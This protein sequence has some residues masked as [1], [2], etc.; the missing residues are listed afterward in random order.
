MGAGKSTVGRLVAEAERVPFRDLDD[1]IEHASGMTVPDIFRE[2][3]EAEFRRLER[4]LLPGMLEPGIVV[5]VGGGAIADAVSWAVLRERAFTVWLDLPL[6]V[7]LERARPES[8]PMLRQRT[9]AQLRELFDSR[10][11]R[12]AEAEGRVDAARPVGA[13]VEEVRSLWAA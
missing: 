9:P 4:E 8:R 3:G 13:V 5:G 7:A 1:V 11:A 6:E 12:Y 10:L 2:R